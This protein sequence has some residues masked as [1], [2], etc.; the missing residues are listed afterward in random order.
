MDSCWDD[1]FF[2]KA[3]VAVLCVWL[4]RLAQC[5]SFFTAT[6][7]A[8]RLVVGTFVEGTAPF[9]E[10]SGENSGE[11]SNRGFEIGK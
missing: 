6:V 2:K 9:F 5:E 10:N 7:L 8:K 3:A 4:G 1:F 11:N